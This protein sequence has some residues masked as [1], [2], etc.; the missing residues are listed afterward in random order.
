M[1]VDG[2]S[3][4]RSRNLG[5]RR[6]AADEQ[7]Q[8][9]GDQEPGDHKPRSSMRLTSIVGASCSP[10]SF[11]GPSRTA[12]PSAYRQWRM[13]AEVAAS[14][15]SI[16]MTSMPSIACAAG[17]VAPASRAK[18]GR[19]S[20]VSTVASQTEPAGNVPGQE[21]MQPCAVATAAPPQPHRA[22]LLEGKNLT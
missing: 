5:D 7:R 17:V 13:R 20:M 9:R 12:Q 6:S 22:G 21:A 2:I 18:V 19:R 16:G 4:T 3:V 1:F 10:S 14:T 8:C 11:H 15:R